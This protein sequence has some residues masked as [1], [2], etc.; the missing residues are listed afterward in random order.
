MS[1]GRR[2]PGE[3]L[4]QQIIEDEQ[5]ATPRNERS[6]I[7]LTAFRN[8]WALIGMLIVALFLLFLIAIVRI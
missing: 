1:S 5:R 8:F 7:I 6:P 2:I 4:V 3:F